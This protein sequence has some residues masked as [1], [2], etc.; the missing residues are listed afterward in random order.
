MKE[1]SYYCQSLGSF[2]KEYGRRMASTSHPRQCTP[3]ILSPSGRHE[4]DAQLVKWLKDRQKA[5][6]VFETVST[7]VQSLVHNPAAKMIAQEIIDRAQQAQRL[8]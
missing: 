1:T 7:L 4:A 2:P 8:I 6:G 5:A 3:A